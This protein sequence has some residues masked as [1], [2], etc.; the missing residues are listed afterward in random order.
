MAYEFRLISGPDTV[1]AAR[2]R[3]AELADMFVFR[4]YVVAEV[5]M[6]DGREVTDLVS[7]DETDDG[8]H[9]TVA[10]AT[11]AYIEWST[12]HGRTVL[13]VSDC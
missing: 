9:D 5:T 10:E 8:P 11:D 3:A 4:H 13:A 7:I 6:P 12:G 1:E 2:A